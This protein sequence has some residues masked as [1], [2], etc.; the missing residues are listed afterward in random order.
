[1]HWI[2]FFYLQ[3]LTLCFEFALTMDLGFP[4]IYIHPCT[5]LHS[6]YSLQSSRLFPEPLQEPI[7]LLFC[8]VNTYVS[9]YHLKLPSCF[10]SCS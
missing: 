8:F 2:H 4:Q 1:M 3:D 7:P 5:T 9:I 10:K 6:A